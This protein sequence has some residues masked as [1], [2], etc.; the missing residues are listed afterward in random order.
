MAEDGKVETARGK[1]K[2]PSAWLKSDS[3]SD[4]PGDHVD[5]EHK[6]F[7]LIHWDYWDWYVTLHVWAHS[8]TCDSLR[9]YGL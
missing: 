7:Q 8:V 5:K 9:P 6:V 4:H 2:G 3:K 1:W